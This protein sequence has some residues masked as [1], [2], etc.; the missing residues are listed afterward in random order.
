MKPTKYDRTHGD[1][2]ESKLFNNG[3]RGRKIRKIMFKKATRRFV[4][5]LSK[6][7]YQPYPIINFNKYHK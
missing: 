6:G 2:L 1:T 3:I 4:K 7:D 5:D